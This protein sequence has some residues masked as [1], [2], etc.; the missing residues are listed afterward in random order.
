MQCKCRNTD[1]WKYKLS[2]IKQCVINGGKYNEFTI[3]AEC[4]CGVRHRIAEHR[5]RP[6]N[7]QYL[8]EEHYQRMDEFYSG[9]NS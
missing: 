6:Y 1:S 7:S 9:L 4:P 5:N 8:F 2:P 3:Y